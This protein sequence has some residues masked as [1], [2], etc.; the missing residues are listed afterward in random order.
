MPADNPAI[1]A[2]LDAVREFCLGDAFYQSI[3]HTGLGTYLTMQLAF[4]ELEQGDRRAAEY[5]RYFIDDHAVH[6]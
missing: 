2:T 3:A 4:V 1:V 5:Y 6:R